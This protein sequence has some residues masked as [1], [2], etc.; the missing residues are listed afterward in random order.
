MSEIDIDKLQMVGR[1][2]VRMAGKISDYFPDAYEI[3][4]SMQ[5]AL[6]RSK[7]N[8]TIAGIKIPGTKI[9]PSGTYKLGVDLELIANELLRT[10]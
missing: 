8:I 6:D 4:E 2:I 10:K 1:E 7:I 5:L 3:S 9:S